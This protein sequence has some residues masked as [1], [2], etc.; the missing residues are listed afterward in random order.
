MAVLGMSPH[1]SISLHGLVLGEAPTSSCQPLELVGQHG[2]IL[3]LVACVQN[4]SK[5]KMLAN[6]HQ[7]AFAAASAADPS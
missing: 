1:P 6:A 2:L 5:G 4:H 3:A 7:R